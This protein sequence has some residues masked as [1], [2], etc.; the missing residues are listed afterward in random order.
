MPNTL[1]VVL[2]IAAGVILLILG[3]GYK[4]LKISEKLR[5]KSGDTITLPHILE[6]MT[7]GK[8]IRKPL[9]LLAGNKLLPNKFQARILEL[10]EAGISLQQLYFLKII[11]FVLCAAFI[12]IMGYSNF[13]YKTKVI[14]ETSGTGANV[15]Y[16][17]GT[18]DG[19]KYELFTQILGRVKAGGKF[20][21]EGYQEKYA[22]AEQAAAEYLNTSD[23][24]VLKENTEWFLNTL[25]DVKSLKMISFSN[26]III[27]FSFLIPEAVLIIRWVIRG[28]VYKREIIKL[29]YIFELLARVE[30]IK[31][32]DIIYELEK[33]SG[34]YSKYFHEFSQLFKYDKKR[35]FGY[36]RSR[37]IKSLSNMANILEVYSLSDRET[38]LQ[39][40]ERG[41]MERDEAMIM[42][43]DE[44]MD[45]VDLVAFLSIAPLVYE[46][47]RLLLDPMLD[48]IYKAFEF[49]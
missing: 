17:R 24:Q 18:P 4:T 16:D 32:L 49:M 35:A 19:S 25:E 12:F 20:D 41:V 27:F 48:M 37:N 23:Q 10:S 36:L 8:I 30:G 44:T 15:F 7:S 5:G 1:T 13:S 29:E 11:C 3:L 34:I 46:L 26:I 39:I 21:R 14:I 31:T 45:F 2:L 47:A 40:M 6:R 43:A 22:L 33:S 42:T 9:D 38:A 28:S